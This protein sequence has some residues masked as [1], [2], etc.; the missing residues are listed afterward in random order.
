MK[1]R[2]LI[3]GA[4]GFIGKSL[5]RFLSELNYEVICLDICPCPKSLEFFKKTWYQ[6]SFIDSDIGCILKSVSPSVV[7][8]LATTLFPNESLKSPL[9]DCYENLFKSLI[10]FEECYKNGAR[11]IIYT[12]SAGT[13]YGES[14]DVLYENNPTY[15]NISYGVTKLCVEHYLRI[16]SDKYNKSSISL[17]ISNPFGE[18]QSIMGNQGVIPIFL[19]KIFNKQPIEIW[20]DINATRDYIYIEQLVNAFIAAIDYQGTF[21][22]FNIGSG[23]SYSLKDIINIIE[24]VLDKKA[25]LIMSNREFNKPKNVSLSIDRAVSELSIKRG[26]NIEHHIASLAKYHGFIKF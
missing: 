6:K 12:S 14:S 21:R 9:K 26:V 23:T 17:R 24:I 5:V 19:N 25:K 8:H 20:G 18:E 7:I 13:V 3:T 2:V 16:I 15:P 11:K 4:G 10:F 1:E 22:E